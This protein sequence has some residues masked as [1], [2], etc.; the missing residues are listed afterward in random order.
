[1]EFID[2]IVD[3]HKLFLRQD[4]V[5]AIKIP[6]S[7]YISVKELYPRFQNDPRVKDY[8]PSFT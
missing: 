2:A 6:T 4:E 1:M 7:K 3:G 5:R 8:L